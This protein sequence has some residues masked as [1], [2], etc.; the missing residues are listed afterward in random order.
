MESAQPILGEIIETQESF[1]PEFIE[2][3][4]RARVKVPTIPRTAKNPFYKSSYAPLEV[5]IDYTYPVFLAE[6]IAVFQTIE[7]KNGSEYVITQLVHSTGGFIRCTYAI[8]TE[9][10]P[11]KKG[12]LITYARRYSLMTLLG[13]SADDDTDGN[14][15][16]PPPK[17]YNPYLDAADLKTLTNKLEEEKYTPEMKQRLAKALGV[18]KSTKILKAD[19]ADVLVKVANPEFKESLCTQ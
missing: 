17:S 8:P 11:Q 2:A 18:E 7:I 16:S 5:V 6:D 9:K 10:D 1:T 12:I 3:F 15:V 13:V 19:L 4:C 14:G